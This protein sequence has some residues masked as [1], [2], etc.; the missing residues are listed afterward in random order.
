MIWKTTGV[1]LGLAAATALASACSSESRGVYLGE[2]NPPTGGFGDGNADAAA[3]G[4]PDASTALTYC[5]TSECP[6]GTI[7]CESSRSRCDVDPMSDRNSCGACGAACPKDSVRQPYVAGPFLEVTFFCDRG[8]CAMACSHDHADCDGIPDNGCEVWLETTDNCGGCGVKCADG[9]PCTKGV[10][11]CPAPFVNCN[12]QCVDL[13]SD[14]TNCGACGQLCDDPAPPPWEFR[15]FMQCTKGTCGRSC[16]GGYGDCDGDRATNGCEQRLNDDANCGAC[17]QACANGTKCVLFDDA[18]QCGCPAGLRAC[19]FFDGLRCLDVLS[20]PNNCGGCGV[21]CQSGESANA[22][23]ASSAPVCRGGVCD[24]LCRAGAP[25]ATASPGTAARSISRPIR[26]I[27][28]RAITRV[29]SRS[30]SPA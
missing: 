26:T 3:P 21:T 16:E 14:P 17:G 4:S 1:L 10:C 28:D 6:A 18:W 9:E 15:D 22:N 23:L 5:P 20:D 8:K 27:V 25:T 12:G 19:P 7:T 30:V 29:T 24:L 2:R 11:G 13:E